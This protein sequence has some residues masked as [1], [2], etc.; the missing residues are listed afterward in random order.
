MTA[1]SLS[2]SLEDEL[3]ERIAVVVQERMNQPRWFDIEGLATHLGVEVRQV[4]HW[5]EMGL[6]ARIVGKRLM[7]RLDEVDDWLDSRPKR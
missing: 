4:R 2:V 3:I 1:A 6:E 5:R 7:F